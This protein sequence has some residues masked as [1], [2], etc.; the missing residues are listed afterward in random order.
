LRVRSLKD[1]VDWIGEGLGT[2]PVETDM[3]LNSILL[4]IFEG[5][6]GFERAVD[7]DVPSH[8]VLHIF[9][10]SFPNY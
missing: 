1:L 2:K 8:D 7:P 5:F 9:F 3:A 4:S 10:L 6:R